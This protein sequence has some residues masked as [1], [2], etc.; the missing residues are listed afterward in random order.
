MNRHN[1]FKLSAFAASVLLTTNI[2]AS[3]TKNNVIK[4]DILILGGEYGEIVV[5]K[6]L[7]ELNAN[8]K[9][10]VVEKNSSFFSC[11]FSNVCLT[12]IKDI[13]FED[14]SFDY[15]SSILKYNYNF[16]N[17]TIV[18]INREKNK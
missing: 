2:E 13:N 11:L 7:K 9:V 14:L 1:L 4:T 18:E 10:T 15:N 5:Q 12:V 17:E 8:L 3:K 6:Y 16:I